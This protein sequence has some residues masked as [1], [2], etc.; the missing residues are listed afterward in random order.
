MGIVL[1]GLVLGLLLPC[2]EP[3][4]P[5]FDDAEEQLNVKIAQA[6]KEKYKLIQDAKDWENPYLVVRKDG[7]EIISKAL[8][9]GR[10]TVPVTELQ[11]T[12]IG[13]PVDAW[14]YGRV[15]A[16]QEIG[17]RSDGDDKAIEQNKK[18]AKEI[19]EKLKVKI[20]WWP[21]A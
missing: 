5:A 11:K 8:P 17:I 16:V 18:T 3:R 6:D 12:L 14:P 2:L 1:R 19:L 13:L 15:A 7:V 9:K 20:E 4:Q 21:S 10:K